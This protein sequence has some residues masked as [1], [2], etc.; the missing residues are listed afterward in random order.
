MAKVE[1]NDT[2]ASTASTTARAHM[3]RETP[4][5]PGS[6]RWWWADRYPNNP[7]PSAMA[8]MNEK[9]PT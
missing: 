8:A 1:Q 9:R 7:P 3:I 4:S 6:R 2:L 5:G